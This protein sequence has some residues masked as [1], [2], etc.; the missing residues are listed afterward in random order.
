MKVKNTDSYIT[1]VPATVLPQ[2]MSS[3]QTPGDPASAPQRH[4]NHSMT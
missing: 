4:I 3:E 2:F 1:R